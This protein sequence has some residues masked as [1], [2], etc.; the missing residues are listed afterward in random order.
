MTGRTVE[1]IEI[2]TG[3]NYAKVS[4]RL[5]A[6]HEDHTQCQIKTECQF[7]DGYAIFSATVTTKK[8]AFTGHSMAKVTG[9]K[10]F[11]KQETIA[12]G[13]ALAFAGYLSSGDIA[14]QEE[15]ADF[16]QPTISLEHRLTAL[17][18]VWAT[19]HAEVLGDAGKDEQRRL[20]AQWVQQTL[21]SEF[22]INV[23]DF[24]D[25]STDDMEQCEEA[26]KASPE[27]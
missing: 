6:F 2:G 3:I 27:E 12:V 19:K 4:S 11:E 5:A 17:K 26:V 8:G 7:K 10:A 9:K 14:S 23:N 22:D 18:K 16:H 13:R 25:W 24:G 15:M 21:G 20:F 1:T